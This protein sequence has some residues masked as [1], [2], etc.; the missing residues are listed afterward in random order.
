MPTGLQLGEGAQNPVIVGLNPKTCPELVVC[1]SQMSVSEREIAEP[2]VKP[3]ELLL[4]DA[5]A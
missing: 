4:R 3:G 5:M 2:E 1:L